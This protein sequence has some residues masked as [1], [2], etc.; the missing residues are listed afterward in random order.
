MELSSGAGAVPGFVGRSRSLSGRRSATL[1]GFTGND[2]LYGGAGDDEL[3]GGGGADGLTGGIG[4]A[5]LI[6]DTTPFQGGSPEIGGADTL[7]GGA[8]DDQLFG[9][10]GDA[11]LSGGLDKDQVNG[12]DGNDVLL[13]DTQTQ[14]YTLSMRSTEYAADANSGDRSRDVFGVDKEIKDKGVVFAQLISMERYRGR[15]TGAFMVNENFQI[16]Q[17]DIRGARRNQRGGGEQSRKVA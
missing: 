6:G 10:Y 1:I 4:R 5:L 3:H 2:L 11:V 7:E 8:G 17:V 12:Q 9:L 16:G 15:R 14:T 13:F